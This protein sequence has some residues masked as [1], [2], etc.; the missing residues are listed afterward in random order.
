[1]QYPD[2]SW[3]QV[4]QDIAKMEQ[5]L[6]ETPEIIEKII[7]GINERQTIAIKVQQAMRDIYET[8]KDIFTVGDI[9]KRTGIDAKQIHKAM[10]KQTD[11]ARYNKETKRYEFTNNNV[12][13]KETKEVIRNAIKELQSQG[14]KE[15]STREITE[16]A[17]KIQ[18]F[19]DA[20]EKRIE[21]E[22]K[23]ILKEQGYQIAGYS[24]YNG[25]QYEYWSQE[26]TTMKT[27]TVEDKAIDKITEM[28]AKT[29]DKSW[30][31]KKTTKEEIEKVKD[32]HQKMGFNEKKGVLVS[33][34]GRVKEQIK[35]EQ[36]QKAEKCIKNKIEKG[37]HVSMSKIE[38][39]TGV[40]RAAAK[41]AIKSEMEKGTIEAKT[42]KVQGKDRT[43][44]VASSEKIDTK[45]MDSGKT[46]T[47]EKTESR[48]MEKTASV[49][50]A[51][52]GR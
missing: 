18:F 16:M 23:E 5:K 48:D 15:I 36:I 24:K 37:E 41:N 30:A 50:S 4:K 43:I 8:G 25:R 19:G 32:F 14:I 45:T 33:S 27:K 7:K 22:M 34:L 9:I 42:I 6:K 12:F 39:D 13:Q 49:T 21:K 11:I 31:F 52:R 3:E 38:K 29:Q 40:S 46:A 28:Y 47:V 2:I 26:K 35:Q 51:G 10:E 17:R 44:Y 1:M 20:T